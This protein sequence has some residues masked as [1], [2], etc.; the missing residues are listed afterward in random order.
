M[1]DEFQTWAETYPK[2]PKWR[3]GTFTGS[4]AAAH[5]RNTVPAAIEAA[6]GDEAARYRIV[7]SAGQSEW[8][9]TPWVALL[10]PAGA[11]SVEEGIY[12]VYLL[13]LGCD[14][15][16]LTLNQGCTTL[17]NSA[18]KTAARDELLR[19]A[20]VMRARV[21]HSAV[22]LTDLPMDLAATGWRSE[23]YEAGQ[24][25]TREYHTAAFPPEAELVEDLREALNLYQ[26]V[27]RAG[28]WTPD[29]TLIEIARDEAGLE[30]LEQA[31]VYV[32]H[33]KIERNP[34]HSHKVKKAQGSTCK[35]CEI[36]PVTVYGQL[37]Q[38]MVDAHHLK[39]LAALAAG[40]TVTFDVHRD[41]AVLCPNCHRAIHRM[42]D[43]SDL[44]GLRTH[45]A[46]AKVA[47]PG[48]SQSPAKSHE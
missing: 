37:A 33:R 18:G 26:A 17:N 15:L 41:F 30:T 23:L 36:D 35:G 25:L 20:T 3:D 32:Q 28:E 10:D 34:S 48:G 11:T 27:L 46:S 6:L 9:H 45:V 31:K 22:R 5:V 21:A 44:D 43:V 13:S 12:V 39:P 1:R 4:P 47:A 42:N 2:A 19:R 14:R 24:I 7:G 16:Y 8:T 29:D 40:E 38:M